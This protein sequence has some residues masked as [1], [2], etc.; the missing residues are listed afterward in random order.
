MKNHLAAGCFELVRQSPG[1]EFTIVSLSRSDPKFQAICR[2]F[3]EALAALRSF[4]E[5]GE[6]GRA[7]VSEFQRIYEDLQLELMEYV[8]HAKARAKAQG[9]Q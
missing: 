5:Q 3:G 8:N 2:D 9:G 6:R 7:R 4:Q 1:D